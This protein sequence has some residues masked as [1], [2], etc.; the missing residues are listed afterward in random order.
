MDHINFKKDIEL[1]EKLEIDYVHIDV[2][3]GLAVPRYGIYPEI[4]RKICEFTNINMDLHLMVLDV[5]FALSQFKNISNIK[6]VSFHL[7]KNWENICRICDSIRA[8]NFKPVGILNLSTHPETILELL[9][10]CILN[11]LS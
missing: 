2:M 4:V 11:Y 3:D 9:E 8:Y 7:D 5:E 10:I 6:Y 1:I